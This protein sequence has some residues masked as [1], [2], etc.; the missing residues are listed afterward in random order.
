[1]NTTIGLRSLIYERIAPMFGYITCL[2]SIL[3]TLIYT[4]IN[5]NNQLVLGYMQ[6]I[7]LIVLEDKYVLPRLFNRLKDFHSEIENTSMCFL[8]KTIYYC[9]ISLILLLSSMYYSSY[10]WITT[11]GALMTITNIL[12]FA[13]YLNK[14]K[15]EDLNNY[16]DSTKFV[17]NQA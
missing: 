10:W 8:I 17:S 1:M 15:S 4:F 5:P 9:N 11:T 12:Y 16:T 14:K 3:N 7:F 6:S 2:F 13:S